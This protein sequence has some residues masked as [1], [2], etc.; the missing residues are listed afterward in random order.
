M[1]RNFSVGSIFDGFQGATSTDCLSGNYSGPFELSE[2][3]VRNEIWVQT[4]FTNIKFINNIHSSGGLF[5]W[6]PGAYTPARVPLPYPPYGTLNFF[7]QTAK[8]V[9]DG[10]KSHRGTAI[11][12]QQTGPVIDVLYSAAGNSADEAYYATG[13]SATTSRSAPPTTTTPAPARRP[14]APASSRRSAPTRPTRA[15]STRASTRARSSRPATTGS[16]APRC[17][18]P[19]TP[20]RRSS[21]RVV[22]A[23]GITP[24]YSVKFKS[25]EASSIYYTTDGSTPTTASTEWKP[26]RA[27]ALPLPLQLRAED[28]PEVDRPRLQGQHLGGQVAGARADRHAR[29]RR[30]HRPGD[31]G[32]DDGR[33]GAVRGVHPRRRQG[34]HGEHHRHRHLD[35]R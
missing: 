11:L 18:T 13:S 29:H 6:P 16:C 30:R 9:L 28:D 31:A 22:D 2:P 12:P 21:T 32:A 25:N 15:C 5:M 24:V 34:V 1:N 17:S 4:T 27:R 7:D 20:R 8:Q 3:E 33:S 35:G 23:D 26:P 19:T 14:A 10:I